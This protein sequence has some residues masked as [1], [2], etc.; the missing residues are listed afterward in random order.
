MPQLTQ[1]RAEF[2]WLLSLSFSLRVVAPAVCYA[3]QPAKQKYKHQRDPPKIAFN[4]E[5]LG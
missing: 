1:E 5:F 2:Y 3:D 4:S